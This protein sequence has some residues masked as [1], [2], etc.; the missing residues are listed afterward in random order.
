M[1]DGFMY[2]SVVYITSRSDNNAITFEYLNHLENVML[3]SGCDDKIL[4]MGDFNI[5]II[6]WI[7]SPNNNLCACMLVTKLPNWSTL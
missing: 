4:V 7:L 3:N 6:D 5:R 1:P 2:I